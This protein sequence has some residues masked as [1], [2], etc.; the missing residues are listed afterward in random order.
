MKRVI[1][2]TAIPISRNEVVT[3]L[4][5]LL[6]HS[7]GQDTEKFENELATY[8][9]A[10][11]A[12]AC[13]TGRTAL[14]TA[15]RVLNLNRGDEI[16]VPAYV[17]AIVFEVVLRL[18]LKPVLVDV[19]VATYNI[20]HELIEKALTAKTRAIIPVHLF[21]RPAN[22]D[23]ISE[24]ARNHD[25]YLIEDAAQ[26]LGAECRKAKVGTLGDMAIFSFGPGKSI[27]SGEGGAITVNNDELLERVRNAR[28][29][30]SPPNLGWA[31]HLVRNILAMKT[32]ASPRLYGFIRSRLEG[33]IDNRETKTLS[34]CRSLALNKNA[35][36]LN[37]TVRLAKM[38]AFSARIARSQ[39][40]KIDQFN[41]KRIANAE[42]LEAQ[43]LETSNF[44]QCPRTGGL[45][46][47]TF[48][49]YPI[50]ILKGSRDLVGEKMLQRGVDSERPYNY[51]AGFLKTS[52]VRAPN[53]TLIATTILTV[54]NNPL[55]E[56]REIIETADALKAA[57]TMG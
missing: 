49:R 54:P 26:A 16:I 52:N 22:M 8:L 13:N 30:L 28:D 44:A 56:N 21:G 53:A 15:L 24:I 51:L 57:L 20:D 42:T 31:T 7:T 4:E 55:L 12:F 48:T 39:L 14:H 36:S 35:T 40:Q 6:S 29:K 32:F 47:N 46:K 11:K 18:G 27:T 17:C 37:P 3:A 23:E 9:G 41:A 2:R 5:G 10:K 19:D 34:N 1:P 50:R 43:L 33:E 45:T 25:L 38:P